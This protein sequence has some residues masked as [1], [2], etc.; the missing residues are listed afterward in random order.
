MTEGN[1]KSRHCL[2]DDDDSG[3]VEMWPAR[4]AVCAGRSKVW[5]NEPLGSINPESLNARSSAV[6]VWAMSVLLTQVTVEPPETW[7][8]C[9]GNA[10][11]STISTARVSSNSADAASSKAPIRSGFRR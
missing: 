10:Q 7:S 4:V 1:D 8:E 5:W 9:G 3:H 11:R 2:A 6:T